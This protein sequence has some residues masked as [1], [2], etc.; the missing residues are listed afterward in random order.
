[1]CPGG[2]GGL[3]SL[4]ESESL[5]GAA[6]RRGG[7][8]L[9]MAGPDVRAALPSSSGAPP[10]AGPQAPCLPAAD[11][12]AIEVVGMVWGTGHRSLTLPAEVPRTLKAG[13]GTTLVCPA[14]LE[15]TQAREERD[16]SPL[17]PHT[18]LVRS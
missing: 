14:E 16:G 12:D 7:G 18:S 1:M 6:E 4:P 11:A 9:H 3:G 13:E 2:W 10:P 5:K 8:C 17:A 15:P